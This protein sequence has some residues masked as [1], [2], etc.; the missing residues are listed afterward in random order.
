MAKITYSGIGSVFMAPVNADGTL[1]AG[2]GYYKVGDA[3]PLSVQV[4]TSTKKHQ[5]RE[6]DRAGQ[7]I[8]SKTIIEDILG[9]LTLHQ[10][11]AQNLA[12]ALSGDY[13]AEAVTG[14]SVTNEAVTAVLDEFVRLDYAEV[15][16]VT[17]ARTNGEGAGTWAATTAYSAGDY[18]IP[19]TPNTRF[20]KCTT[21]GTSGASEPTWPTT[22]GG[23]V[24]DGTVTWTDMGTIEAVADTDYELQARLGMIQA[25]STGGIEDGEPLE[26]DY[27]YATKD[28]YKVNIGTEALIRV[29]IL[30]DLE[31][32][33]S[34]EALS[35]ELKS[36]VLNTTAEINFISE[37][38][39]DHE[40]L[41]F[42]LTI[43]T[44]T[45]E[46]SPGTINGV[47]L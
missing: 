39:S 23:T 36:V 1:V 46:T 41:P 35:M 16:A 33:Y 28:A 42:G 25:L 11:S 12:W 15:S 40:T 18:I 26:V 9:N 44:P 38:D 43:E 34:G 8:A 6:V 5:S 17:V 47:P 13:E 31:D 24:V 32:E 37:Q 30:A 22:T 27:T 3:H 10:W 19:T 4:T 29:A 14:A 21:A 45:G 20:Y 2:K 7:I